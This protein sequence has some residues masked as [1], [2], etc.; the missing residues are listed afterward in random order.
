LCKKHKQKIIGF[1]GDLIFNTEKPDGTPRKVMD[2][3]KIKSMG[4]EP[5][6]DLETG[7]RLAYNDYLKK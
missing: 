7:I 1:E 6:I 4:W 5:K 3:S 2:I